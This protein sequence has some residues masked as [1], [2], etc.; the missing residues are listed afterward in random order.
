MDGYGSL[1]LV[2]DED[3]LRLLVARFLR[4]SGYHVVEASDGPEALDRFDLDGPF[5]M[6]LVDLNLPHISGVDV[7]R[8]L[9]TRRPDQPVMICSAAVVPE[10]E[11]FLRS[12]GIDH[13]LTKPY[14]PEE[15]L[16][17]IAHRLQAA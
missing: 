6:A 10:S 14:H 12:L 8:Y 3:V 16:R 9:L 17:Q 13:F 5:D 2:E 15:L 7:C 1:L 4:S 11:S